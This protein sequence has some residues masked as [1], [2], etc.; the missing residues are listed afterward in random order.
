MASNGKYLLVNEWARMSKEAVDELLQNF[1]GGTEKNYSKPL[2]NL[3]GGI[4]SM[5]M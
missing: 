2:T 3:L 5:R 4:S 1:P